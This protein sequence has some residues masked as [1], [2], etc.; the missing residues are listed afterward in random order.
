MVIEPS[1][2]LKTRLFLNVFLLIKHNV[3]KHNEAQILKKVSVLWHHKHIPE[4][5][6][7]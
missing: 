3:D 6:Y 4:P 2:D 5:R 1:C 7:Q